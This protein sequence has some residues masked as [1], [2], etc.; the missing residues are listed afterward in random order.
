MPSVTVSEL[1]PVN[2]DSKPTK[3]SSPSPVSVKA[4]EL[5]D[6]AIARWNSE[7]APST[8]AA[9]LDRAREVASILEIDTVVREQ[10]NEKPEREVQL[11]KESGL[12]TFLGPQEF[13]G[14]GGLWETAYKLIREISKSDGS[15]GQL[16]GYHLVWFWHARVL[17]PDEQYFS[18]IEDHVKNKSFFGG[19]VNPRDSDLAIKDLG[20]EISFS[21]QKSFS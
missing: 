9:W 5:S 6:E 7:L 13:G 10:A 11:L 15:I 1:A 20:N 18:F 4:L 14:A 8:E 2:G 12:V 19:A 17:L 3:S 16:L 21:G